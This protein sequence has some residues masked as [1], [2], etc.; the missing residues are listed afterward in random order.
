MVRTLRGGAALQSHLHTNNTREVALLR[1]LVALQARDKP[2]LRLLRMNTEMQLEAEVKPTDPDVL[3]LLSRHAS[4]PR[5][6]A[7]AAAATRAV[8][9]GGNVGGAGVVGAHRV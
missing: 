9:I 2:G 3:Q 5:T 1:A 7:A 6:T 4:G 8:V